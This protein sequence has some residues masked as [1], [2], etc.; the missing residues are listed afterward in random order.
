MRGMRPVRLIRPKVTG[1]KQTKVEQDEWEGVDRD[2]FDSLR[3]LRRCIAAERHVPAYIVFGDATLRDMARVRPASLRTMVCVRGVGQH[4]LEDLGERFVQHVVDYC[5]EHKLD[6]DTVVE[7]RPQPAAPTKSHGGASRAAFAL[8][9]KGMSVD[10]VAR[11]L[12]RSPR[13]VTK[14]LLEYIEEH[15][16]QDLHPWVNDEM[17]G[18]VAEAAMLLGTRR[19]GPIFDRLGGLVSQEIIRLVARHLEVM[20]G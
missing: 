18:R 10:E 15:K 13:T 16:P 4:K 19:V 20:T 17:Y 5:R 14:Y 7:S 1:V 9:A 8:F 11:E 3:E 6:T 2:L 12:Q